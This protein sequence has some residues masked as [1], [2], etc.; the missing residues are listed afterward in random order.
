MTNRSDDAG[1]R[2]TVACAL[3][4]GLLNCQKAAAPAEEAAP[5]QVCA[6]LSKTATND[7]VSVKV[8]GRGGALKIPATVA[9]K[10]TMAGGVVLLEFSRPSFGTFRCRYQPGPGD[11]ATL[12][13]C[14]PMNANAGDAVAS[15]QLSVKLD[16]SAGP[17]AEGLVVTACAET[18]KGPTPMPHGLPPGFRT[19][20]TGEWAPPEDRGVP[21]A[22]EPDPF[23]MTGEL[24]TAYRSGAG[25]TP[26]VKALLGDRFA[27]SYVEVIE[28]P[29]GQSRDSIH[30][31]LWF[32]SYVQNASV[33]VTMKNGVVE[34]VE[35]AGRSV[36]EGE[37]EVR[38]AVRL[39]R[40]DPALV[41]KLG[42][43]EGGA[44]LAVPRRGDSWAGNRVLDVRFFD[45]ARISRFMA[46]VDLTTQ[47]VLLAGS[48]N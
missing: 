3:A 14:E 37:D 30:V 34:R 16:E 2:A 33:A 42:D 7:A 9:T 35:K 41:G 40:E 25:D 19:L 31:K 6:T 21:L 8:P 32:F 28:P 38:E 24:E 36:P 11:Q 22:S 48:A 29:K 46:T 20:P 17:V 18:V 27:Y 44:M 45:S 1:A 13:G 5:F 39:A 10:G 15:D 26:A 12:A 43:L 4:F 23:A 47:K